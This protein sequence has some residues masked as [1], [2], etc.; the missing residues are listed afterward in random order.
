M[1]SYK[2]PLLLV[3][4]VPPFS[5]LRKPVKVTLLPSKSFLKMMT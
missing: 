2:L 4:M 3:A 5:D 1:S